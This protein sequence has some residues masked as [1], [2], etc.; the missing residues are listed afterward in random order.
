MLVPVFACTYLEAMHS[1][2]PAAAIASSTA[3]SLASIHKLPCLLSSQHCTTL[4]QMHTSTALVI[5]KLTCVLATPTSQEHPATAAAAS[6]M[7]SA[8]HQSR[9]HCLSHDVLTTRPRSGAACSTTQ[10]C[11]WSSCFA[12]FSCSMSA[13]LGQARAGPGC[14]TVLARWKSWR[15]SVE[16]TRASW[17]TALCTHHTLV[18]MLCCN[19]GGA[20]ALEALPRCWCVWFEPTLTFLPFLHVILG[21]DLTP[22]LAAVPAAVCTLA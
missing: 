20:A 11:C 14:S 6:D 10:T 9:R 22:S 18:D 21:Q 12:I 13:W 1:S 2:C 8:A 3:H 16:V 17:S 15:M 19:C 5:T 7:Q 4:D